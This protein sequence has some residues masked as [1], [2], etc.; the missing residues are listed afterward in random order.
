MA[1]DLKLDG[2][3][4]YLPLGEVMEIK[5]NLEFNGIFRGA[6]NLFSIYSFHPGSITFYQSGLG[7][8]QR[9]SKELNNILAEMRFMELGGVL[10]LINIK[11]L[12]LN[13]DI[14]DPLNDNSEIFIKSLE[15]EHYINKYKS[16][17]NI[18]IFQNRVFLPH[19][20]APEIIFVTPKDLEILPEIVL[21]ENSDIRL[22]I[23]FNNTRDNI[24]ANFSF[25][26]VDTAFSPMFYNE[27]Q[28]E[29][30]SKVPVLEFKKINPTKYRVVVHGATEDFPLVFS[31]SFHEGW[32]SYL[33]DYK[34]KDIDFNETDYKILDGNDE[35]QA[36]ANELKEFI[37]QGY[38]STLGDFEEK[39]I[40]HI[41]WENNKEVLDYN[42][43]YKID[44][45]S[46]NFQDTIQNDNLT[47]GRFYETWFK[48]P[49]NNNENHL[50]VNGYA[51]SWFINPEE[52]C[53]D[54]IKCVKNPDGSYDFE[55]VIEF[56]PQR[57]FILGSFVSGAVLLSCL[58]CFGWGL[59]KRVK[60]N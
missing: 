7:S 58:G 39:N 40:K 34:K 33:A 20:Y 12:I 18:Y 15:G 43:P 29:V 27:L 31:E 57:F 10:N 2:K 47:S 28:K 37:N 50:M 59:L 60:N 36:D 30:I 8:P 19:F 55:L 41:K 48:K 6:R 14:D 13:L 38:I 11:Y 56:W 42:E 24:M 54:N 32:K 21:Q 53:A 46:K 25:N 3:I 35:D 49:I 16:F 22:A 4:L 45:V 23:Y 26:T 52:I 1:N 5:N 51:N 44:F 17:D 9:I